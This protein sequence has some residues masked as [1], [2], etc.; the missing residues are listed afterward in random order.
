MDNRKKGANGQPGRPGEYEMLDRNMNDSYN[1]PN[2]SHP[3]PQP[4]PHYAAQQGNVSRSDLDV[5]ETT[6]PVEPFQYE[7]YP[8]YPQQG[9]HPA[10]YPAD[11]GVGYF[12]QDD[13]YNHQQMPFAQE[14]EGS[15]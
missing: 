9:G 8:P 6:A 5:L 14:Y 15:G 7:A 3:L 12:H 10:P 11:A 2:A 1:S 4:Q 13:S